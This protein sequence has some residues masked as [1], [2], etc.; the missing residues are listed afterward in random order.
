MKHSE[1]IGFSSILFDTLFGLILFFNLDSFLEITGTYNLILYFFTIF[2]IIHWWLEFK[3]VDDLFGEEVS[4]SLVD[5][6]FGIIY[7][8]LLEFII[9]FSKMFDHINVTLCL[10][11]LFVVDL[12][13]A[14]I[15][16]YV[17][18]W[19]TKDIKR[20]KMMER[21]LNNNIKINITII[22]L[23]SLL[24]AVI[25]FITPANFVIIFIINYLFYVFLTFRYKIIDIEIF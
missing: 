13:W 12:I 1:Q 11:S 19:T 25:P 18:N 6:L 8:M 17:G 23:N 7:L 22:I 2:I 24:V 21:E 5:L 3:S 9:L 14:S 16:R 4:D 10:I 20:I 15:W